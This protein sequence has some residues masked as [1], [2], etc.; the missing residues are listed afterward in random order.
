MKISKLIALFLTLVIS[1]ASFGQK[2]SEYWRAFNSPRWKVN[3]I[4]DKTPE[5]FL[6]KNTQ[7]RLVFANK[8][9]SALIVTFYVYLKAE[10]DS[11]FKKKIFGW[12]ISQ[13]CLTLTD[14]KTD[15]VS[16]NFGQ[17][18]YLLKP[19]HSCHPATNED[20]ELLEKQ[21][22]NFIVKK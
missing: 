1:S 14:G 17:F 22:L 13:S 18:Y 21:I 6:E 3:F 4:V 9:D 5:Y 15:F 20:C 7:G 12:L 8:T 10:M 11:S 19:C 16:F 2:F